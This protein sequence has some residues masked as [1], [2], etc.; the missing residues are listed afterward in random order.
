VILL[1]THAAFWLNSAPEKLSREAARAIR[2]A[3]RSGGLG[4]SSISLWELAI[5]VERGRIRVNTSTTRDFLDAVV[6][7]PSLRVLEIT[8]EI[9]AL[10]ARFPTDFPTDPADRI[11]AATARAY[12]VPLVSRDQRLRESTLLRTIW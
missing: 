3:A 11:I 1:D 7:T 5:L 12:G 2:R 10:S 9:A 6:Q 4:L 8:T